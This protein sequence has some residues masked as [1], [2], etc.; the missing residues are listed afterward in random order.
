MSEA[1]LDASA[2]IAFLRGEPG[3]ERVKRA[4]PTGLICSVN[5]SEVISK[6]VNLG[7]RLEDVARNLDQLRLSVV[8]FDANL[9]HVAASFY[10]LTS[11][12]G[13]SLGDRCCLAAGLVHQL[14]VLTT[15]RVWKT[16]PLDVSIELIR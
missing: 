12:A 15:D 9:A 13:L 11:P 16:L 14:P 10:P 5:L 3:A 6:M 7:G 4:L 1:L 2:L 8:S